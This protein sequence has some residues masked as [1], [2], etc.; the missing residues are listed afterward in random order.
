MEQ[1][2]TKV[3]QRFDQQQDDDVFS[4]LVIR[5]KTYT[6]RQKRKTLGIMMGKSSCLTV[7]QVDCASP[8]SI[9]S[10]EKSQRKKRIFFCL[11][12]IP[13]ENT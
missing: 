11:K 8:M 12:A 10:Q 9:N 7:F 2:A 1:N 4:V 3:S 13:E 6:E 5:T